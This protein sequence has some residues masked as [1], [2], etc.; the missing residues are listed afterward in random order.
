MHEKKELLRVEHLKQYFPI[1]SKG[2][3]PR[4]IGQLHAVDDVSFTIAENETL[5]IVGESGSGKT[6]IGRAILRINRA[7]SGA[8]YYRGNNLFELS[9]KEMREY[10]KEMQ[11]VFQDPYSSLNPRMTVGEIIA[12]PMRIFRTN[13]ETEIQKRVIHLLDLVGL[14]AWY[15][16]RYPHEFSGGQRQRVGIARALALEPKFI[17]C[18]EPV[19][20]LDVSVQ[21]QVLNLL[22]D[23]K[24]ELG[25]SYLF[26]AHGLAVVKHV[27]DRVGVMYLGKLVELADKKDLYDHPLHPYTQALLSAIPVPDPDA[28]HD[29]IILQGEIPSPVD[30]PNRCRFCQRCRFATD[31]CWQQEPPFEEVAPG[32]FAACFNLE[33]IHINTMSEV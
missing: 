1:K 31:R 27:S 32:H 26:I 15:A 9:E 28:A 16:T 22:A 17:V 29:R 33:S 18:D 30:P 23:L 25:L 24:Q 2:L 13:S 8:V 14:S 21:S 5:G 11:I 6:T 20:A 7:T 19:S 4:T 10:R 3:I 12:E